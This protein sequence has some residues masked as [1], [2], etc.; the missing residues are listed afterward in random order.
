MAIT[1]F[2]PKNWSPKLLNV[3]KRPLPFLALAGRDY[4]AELLEYG[5]TVHIG[6]LTPCTVRPYVA[7][8][9]LTAP[10]A[11]SGNDRTLVLD[12]SVYS[13]VQVK[14]TE[15]AEARVNL[16]EE[17]KKGMLRRFDEDLENFLLETISEG[18]G[19]TGSMDASS[20]LYPQVL[21]MIMSMVARNCPL[22]GTA[23]ILPYNMYGAMA[24]SASFGASAAAPSAAGMKRGA[25]CSI[26]GV[27]FYYSTDLIDQCVGLAP[28]ALQ[29]AS[30]VSLETYRID[31]DF[32]TGVK[33][34]CL[35]GA[36]VA[37]SDGCAVYSIS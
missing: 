23:L 20:D 4:E 37:Q 11:L 22:R 7:G 18:A 25:L 28:G 8:T 1:S 16:V 36:K 33:G 31:A 19:I 5:D 6:A 9:A 35:A 12:H 32:A 2:I 15:A 34:F 21:G 29:V 13:H 27:D 30:R 3:Y 26:F 14:D 17:T 24:Q 10:E